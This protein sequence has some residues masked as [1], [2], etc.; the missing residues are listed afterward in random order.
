MSSAIDPGLVRIGV[1]LSDRRVAEVMVSSLRP[2][3]ADVL[4]GRNVDTAVKLVPMLFAIC[5]KAQGVAASLALQAARGRDV[6][7]CLDATVQAEA[8]REHLWRWLLDLPPLLGLAPLRDEFPLALAAVAR[9]DRAWLRD[10]L[11]GGA[12]ARVDQA[13]SNARDIDGGG[14]RLMP[15]LDASATVA[16]WAR[17]DAAFCRAPQ[18]QGAAVETGALARRTGTEGGGAFARRWRARLAE[19]HDW[20][21]GREKVGAGGTVSAVALAQGMGRSLVETAR[22]MLMH[23]IELDG[24]A[25]KSYTIVAPTEWNFH[26]R[27]TL[28]RWLAGREVAGPDALRLMVAEAVAAL[29]PCVR[30]ELTLL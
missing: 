16:L 22:G 24:D 1:R 19:L 7:P 30:W 29:D 14:E 6:A 2:L 21:E 15:A 13:L 25:I 4:R 9:G 27:G 18:L 17:F 12:I 28:A 8:L 20:G 3:A 23:E 11:A 26:P 5:G 10:L